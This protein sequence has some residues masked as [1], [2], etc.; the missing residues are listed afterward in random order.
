MGYGE[1][2]MTAETVDLI[3]TIKEKIGTKASLRDQEA[4]P[5]RKETIHS[6]FRHFL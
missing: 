4:Q 5:L 1:L 3:H 6:P 2:A